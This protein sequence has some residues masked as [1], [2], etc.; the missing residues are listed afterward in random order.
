[1]VVE[2]LLRQLPIPAVVLPD[3]GLGVA[4][5]IVLWGL[6]VHFKSSKLY[7]DTCK[8]LFGFLVVGLHGV[9]DEVFVVEGLLKLPIYRREVGV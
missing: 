9:I 2:V 1:M 8:S 5:E 6:G 4:M 3:I 7:F